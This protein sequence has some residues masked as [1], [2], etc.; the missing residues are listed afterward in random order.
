MLTTF[1]VNQTAVGKIVAVEQMY[2]RS[3]HR[4]PDLPLFGRVNSLDNIRAPRSDL[5]E[6]QRNTPLE[7]VY[8]AADCKLFYTY[9]SLMTPM[10]MWRRGVDAKWGN[11]TCVAGSTG[12]PSAMGVENKLPFNKNKSTPEEYQGAA[13]ALR[14]SGLMVVVTVGAMALLF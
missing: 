10:S 8:E 2:I 1:A 3:S 12:A 6:D 7:F 5:T 4:N 13:G 9:D 14:A 11:G